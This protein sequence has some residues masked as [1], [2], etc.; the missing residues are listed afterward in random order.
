LP[1]AVTKA[2]II[3]R[4]QLP[5]KPEHATP[6]PAADGVVSAR[7]LA[8]SWIVFDAPHGRIILGQ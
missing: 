3:A 7:A 8:A 4:A 2:R 5:Q 6:L 1:S